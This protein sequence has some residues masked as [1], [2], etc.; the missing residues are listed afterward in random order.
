MMYGRMKPGVLTR[1]FRF[2]DIA[3]PMEKK[4]TVGRKF[5]SFYASACLL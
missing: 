1:F 4:S 3:D 2:E 5:R